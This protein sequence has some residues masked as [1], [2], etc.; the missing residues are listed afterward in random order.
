MSD[1][2]TSKPRRRARGTAIVHINQH[3]IKANAK[4]GGF[5]PVITVKRGKRND[6]AHEV[7]IDGPCT[8][9]YSPDK[10]LGCGARVWIETKADVIL[11]TKPLLDHGQIP[12]KESPTATSGGGSKAGT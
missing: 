6:Y 7:V 2:T 4:D 11:K 12:E 9:V 5:R 8:V 3:H 1:E 10:P